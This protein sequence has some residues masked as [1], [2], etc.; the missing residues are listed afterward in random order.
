MDTKFVGGRFR[1][2]VDQ[3]WKK[4]LFDIQKTGCLGCWNHDR[5]RNY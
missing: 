4:V 2:D 3:K 1:I 5:N